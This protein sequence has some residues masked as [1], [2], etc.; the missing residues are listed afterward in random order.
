[1]P[2]TVRSCATALL[3]EKL[4]ARKFPA[5]V[6]GRRQA[7]AFYRAHRAQLTTPAAVRLAEIVVKTQSLGQAVIDRLRL[8]YSFAEVARSYS[9]DPDS[10]APGGVLGWIAVP[11]LPQPL[12]RA[13]ARGADRRRGGPVPAVGGW[14]VLKVLGRRAG[15]HAAVRRGP[16][17]DRRPAHARAPGRAAVGVAGQ[18]RAAAHVTIGS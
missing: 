2:T 4:G 10:V 18:A 13:L 15:A 12:A 3:A 9:M 5:A 17:G 7:L 16:A 11:S 1:M 6:A 14:H 8:G